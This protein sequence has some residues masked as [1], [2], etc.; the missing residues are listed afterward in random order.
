MSF[1]SPS[2]EL[3]NIFKIKIQVKVGEPFY[4]YCFFLPEASFGLR[5]LLLPA[6]MC[7]SI[8]VLITS[9]SVQ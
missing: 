6:L 9:L 2:K 8:C 1:Q 5:V 4:Y 3:E 7:V